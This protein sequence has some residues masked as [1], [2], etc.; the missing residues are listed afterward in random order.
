MAN[1][2]NEQ[3]FRHSFLIAPCESVHSRALFL[4]QIPQWGTVSSHLMPAASGPKWS[5]AWMCVEPL[6]IAAEDM[7]TG[8]IERLAPV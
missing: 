1:Q 8:A 4:S 5:G 3:V 2:Q 7:G 6:F